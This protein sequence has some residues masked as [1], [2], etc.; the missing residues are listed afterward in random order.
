M[1]GEPHEQCWTG[2]QQ[3][4]A[5]RRH[6]LSKSFAKQIP[7][8]KE[9]GEMAA[10]L[11]AQA[12]DVLRCDGEPREHVVRHDLLDVVGRVVDPRFDV[13]LDDGHEVVG[14]AVDPR[15][16]F[17]FGEAVDVFGGL[18]GPWFGLVVDEPVD[19][20]CCLVDPRL[21]LVV[22]EF[23]DA[24]CRFVD[25]V[26]D[27]GEEAV[28]DDDDDETRLHCSRFRAFGSWYLILKGECCWNR[29]QTMPCLIVCPVWLWDS[30]MSPDLQTM[31]TPDSE[32]M[33]PLG[34]KEAERRLVEKV[35]SHHHCICCFS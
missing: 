20:F 17:V 21:G 22:D 16:G 35:E 18:L 14:G 23:V 11:F 1:A 10:V 27:V 33:E 3:K 8:S 6:L 13:V 2:L 24:C 5:S 7:W 4:T 30:Y 12:V 28:H 19:V 25:C 34:Q 15:L 9:K 29:K 31:V 32:S 26:F